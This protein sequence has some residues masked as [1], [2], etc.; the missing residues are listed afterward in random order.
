[1]MKVPE[2]GDGFFPVCLLLPGV[3]LGIILQYSLPIW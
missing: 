2:E 1:M 3:Q